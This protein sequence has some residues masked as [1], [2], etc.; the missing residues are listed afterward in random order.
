VIAGIIIAVPFFKLSK[1]LKG[2]SSRINKKLMPAVKNLEK[3]SNDLNKK[4]E[5]ASK[6]K[7][8]A[9]KLIAEINDAKGKF[10]KIKKESS[11]ISNTISVLRNKS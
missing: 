9:D 1:K 4:M 8:K 6:L 7:Y 5:D 3:A 11:F 2:F 10:N